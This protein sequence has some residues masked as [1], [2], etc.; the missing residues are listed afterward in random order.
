[1]P[2]KKPVRRITFDDLPEVPQQTKEIQTLTSGSNCLS[3]KMDDESVSIEI[4]LRLPVA[5]NG[6][7]RQDL[8]E[9]LQVLKQAEKFIN[10]RRKFFDEHVRTRLQAGN[11]IE[12]GLLTAI[13]V[14]NGRRS[15]D[16]KQRAI[17]MHTKL[18]KATKQL[19]ESAAAAQAT[20]EAEKFHEATE[21][22]EFAPKVTVKVRK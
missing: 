5:R 16:W 10:A 19:T 20:A 1:M 2:V 15:P 22:K 9:T 12:D 11:P 18:I 8:L 7:V 4:N 13:L 21:Y 14:A 3:A 17:E 6:K